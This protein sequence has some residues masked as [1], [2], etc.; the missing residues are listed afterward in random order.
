ML[1]KFQVG[2]R[3]ILLEA[4]SASQRISPEE[5]FPMLQREDVLFV[6]VRE[7][8]ERAEGYI[9]GS[10]HAPRGFL[11]FIALPQG[12]MYSPLL[13]ERE[14]LVLYCGSGNRSAL[15]AKTLR[16]M[17]F[18][19]LFNLWEGLPSWIKAGGAMTQPGAADTG[20][21]DTT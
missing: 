11:E 15:S 3:Q 18:T 2:L 6:D 4:D 1:A 10:F 8:H 14:T 12:L 17:G 5:A 16:D 21:S 20:S 9:P 13:S 7:S 19:N